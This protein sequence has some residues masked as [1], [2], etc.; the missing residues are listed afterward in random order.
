MPA[1]G[2]NITA[3]HTSIRISA[4]GFSFLRN[5]Q[6][7]VFDFEKADGNYYRNMAYCL[8]ENKL[9]EDGNQL[10][11]YFDAPFSSLVPQDIFSMEYARPL[12]AFCYGEIGENPDDYV[13]V[14]NP[15]IGHD[16]S[17]LFAVPSELFRFLQNTFGTKQILHAQTPFISR[18]LKNSK[19]TGTIQVWL[20]LSKTSAYFIVCDNG[21]LKFANRF[22]LLNDNDLLYYTGLL[23]ERQKLSQQDCPLYVEGDGKRIDDLKKHIKTV[24]YQPGIETCA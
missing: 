5:G 2:N 7:Q 15:I 10:K 4:D 20:N 17:N 14:S 24:I 6:L 16:I 1:T 3:N 8:C 22:K 21:T 13:L 9:H 23:Y 12:L 18:A 11:I 19:K